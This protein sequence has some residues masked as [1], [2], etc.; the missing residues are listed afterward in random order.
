M[1]EEID[2]D[3]NEILY[4]QGAPSQNLEMEKSL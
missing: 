4:P 1:N 2:F 3:F